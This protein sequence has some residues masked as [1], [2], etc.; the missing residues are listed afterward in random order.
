MN[1]AVFDIDGTLVRPNPVE[2]ACFLDAFGAAFGFHDV[3][4]DWESYAE[5]TDTGIINEV[6]MERRSRPASIDE[7]GRFR[8]H[9][10]ASFLRRHE[11]GRG[12]QIDG[13]ARLV[14]RLRLDATWT[15]AIAT[16]NFQAIAVHKLRHAGV[17]CLD[18]PMATADD[19]I[20]RSALIRRAMA[21]ART[22]QGAKR[23]EHV[24]YVGD[25]PWDLRA[26]REARIPFLAVGFASG[27][28]PERMVL[29]WVDTTAALE[30]L[31]GAVCW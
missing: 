4:P 13:A 3:S 27:A 5:S 30:R 19:S 29:D 20:S 21:K 2:D 8:R 9:Y 7:L 12:G 15:M 22:E 24:V 10:A 1:L 25:R 23:F 11:P 6:C 31:S 28:D 18:A 26:A 17:R 14:E 16:G